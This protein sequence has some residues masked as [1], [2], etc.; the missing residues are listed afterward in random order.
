MAEESNVHIKVAMADVVGLIAIAMFTWAVA[1]LG[2]EISDASLVAAVAIP[3]GIVTL[4][5]AVAAF[6]NENV[7][8]TA[9]F[10]PLGLF[11][12]AFVGIHTAGGDNAMMALI[13]MGIVI[14]IDAVLSFNQPVRFLPIVLIVAAIA[15]FVTA[16]F[17]HGE[18]LLSAVGWLWMIYSLLSFYMAAGVLFL[19][20]KGKQVLPL[21][22]KG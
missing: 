7:L 5:A 11:F 17:Y 18:D 2:L 21:L 19:V 10:A 15:F 9:I 14:L 6:L 20:M 13:F 22:V 1:G 4:L 8:G 16:L 12:L 3:C